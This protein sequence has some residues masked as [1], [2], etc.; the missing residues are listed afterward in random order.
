MQRSQDRGSTRK[1]ALGLCDHRLLYDRIDVVWR[2]IKNL[3]KLPQRFWEEAPVLV[4]KRVL[5]KQ[6]NIARVKPLGFVE[7]RL[8]PVPLA[9]PSR[10]ISQQFRNP[11][12][13]RQQR[14]CFLKVTHSRV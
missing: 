4:G 6:G 2:D 8:A 11:A 5:G 13:I 10:D 12:A 1:V 14:P 7:V 9:L 3:L